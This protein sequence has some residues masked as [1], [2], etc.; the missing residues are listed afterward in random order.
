MSPNM[1]SLSFLEKHPVIKSALMDLKSTIA[2]VEG[3]LDKKSPDDVNHILQAL[4]DAKNS[5][6]GI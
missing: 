6:V 1:N 5:L 3:S 4:R 2:K